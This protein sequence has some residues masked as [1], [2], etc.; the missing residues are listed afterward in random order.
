MSVHP[1]NRIRSVVSV[2]LFK[3]SKS[4]SCRFQGQWMLIKTT[5][6]WIDTANVLFD[7]SLLDESNRRER[8]IAAMFAFTRIDKIQKEEEKSRSSI[9]EGCIQCDRDQ[10]GRQR[11]QIPTSLIGSIC[12]RRRSM[13]CLYSSSC[14]ELGRLK[15]KKN[16]P[17][18]VSRWCSKNT[19]SICAY[20]SIYSSVNWQ[21]KSNTSV[22]EKALPLRRQCLLDSISS[23]GLFD[24]SAVLQLSSTIVGSFSRSRW[25]KQL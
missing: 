3:Q 20:H 16:D 13:R 4:C 19:W 25:S 1:E 10:L 18:S 14:F 12:S 21:T 11:P 17:I 5:T 23:L 22:R 15:D 24:L 8:R 9:F 2:L 6:S 7:S